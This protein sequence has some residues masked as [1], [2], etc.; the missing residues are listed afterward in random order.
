M[1][2][3]VPVP[4]TAA[5]TT[6]T[7]V[8]T[9]EAPPPPLPEC[10]NTADGKLPTDWRKLT[11]GS[12]QAVPD[13]CPNLPGPQE[14]LPSRTRINEGQCVHYDPNADVWVTESATPNV[15]EK[16]VPAG[17]QILHRQ[18]ITNSNCDV[19]G[20]V[21]SQ[22]LI[23]DFPML[24]VGETATVVMP[25]RADA[26]GPLWSDAYATSGLRA[27]PDMSNN[28]TNAAAA[29]T[30]QATV[31]KALLATSDKTQ[32]WETVQTQGLLWDGQHFHSLRD[33]IGWL[34]GNGGSMDRFQRFHPMAYH[35]LEAMG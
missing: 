10:S 22:K 15:L 33:F 21:G 4:T 34:A 29:V 31:A 2:P 8:T 24:D 19:Q 28:H 5:T 7:A 9:I 20:G 35:L 12:C 3:V 27:D 6:T 17:L 13:L 25:V 26:P 14:D 1:T 11:D 16:P 30:V 32:K 18:D 23:C